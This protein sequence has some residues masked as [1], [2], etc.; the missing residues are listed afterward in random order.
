[1]TQPAP[2]RPV[3]QRGFSLAELTISVVLFSILAG[4]LQ[5]SMTR[6]Q[7]DQVE[8]DVAEQVAGEI[9][10]LANAA[11]QYAIN[12]GE[13]PNETHD[14][15]G[16][17]QL[18][19]N[20]LLKGVPA[21]TPYMNST[22]TR[23]FYKLECIATHFTIRVQPE[24]AEQA[25]LLAAKI[26]GSSVDSGEVLASYPKPI[27][28][29]GDT[30]G[31]M[32]LD[33]STQPTGTWKMGNQFLFNIRDIVTST[34]QSLLNSVQ[35][36]STARPGDMILKPDCPTNMHPVILTALNGVA[37]SPARS[38]HALHTIA[39]DRGDAWLIDMVVHNGSYDYRAGREQATVSVFV[40]C[41]F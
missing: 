13:W 26:P 29:T 4:T 16:A 24:N 7:L 33:G 27:G 8:Q 14:C 35:Y 6:R 39:R 37:I 12:E 11:Q 28:N 22:G 21:T 36:A 18:L 1:M 10:R 9:Y 20:E 23:R 25:D 5:L 30:G 32:A 2:R 31:F 38:I 41:S 3:R 40:K 19:S 17:Y 34:A 15:T